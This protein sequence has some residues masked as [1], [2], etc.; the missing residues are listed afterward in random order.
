ME[1]ILNYNKEIM[2]IL[3]PAAGQATRMRGLPKFLL[4]IDESYTTLLE[5]HINNLS[6]ILDNDD[7]ILI[8]IRPDLLPIVKS[9]NLS[10]ENLVFIEMVTST[11]NETILNLS[12]NSDSYHFQLIMPD[13]YFLGMQPYSQLDPNPELCD[14]AIW[15]IRDE[16]RGKLGEVKIDAN[17]FLCDLVDKNPNTMFDYSWGSLTF[18]RKLFKYIKKEE[19]HIGYSVSSALN[20]KQ[21]ISTKLINGQYF[22]CG[23]PKEYIELFRKLLL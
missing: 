7:R 5:N 20:D 15:K 13:T 6:N 10:A 1:I 21:Q 22:D 23:T 14:L 2:D 9:L 16:Q 17:N 18:S 4:P 11:M 19:P 12:E 3:I 8:G